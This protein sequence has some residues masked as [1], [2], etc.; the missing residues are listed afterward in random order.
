MQRSEELE[1]DPESGEVRRDDAQGGWPSGAEGAA[2]LSH[3]E[4]GPEGARSR[5]VDVG[6]KEATARS[7][8]A[9]ALVVFPEGELASI[10]AGG[11]P[12]GP[13]EEVA[14]VAGILAAKDTGRL[15]PMCHP[16]GLDLVEVH[17]EDLGDDR[18]EVLC[19]ASCTG[20][21]G[22]EMEAMVG[23]SVAAL[24][25]YDMTKALSKGIRIEGVELL[26]KTGGK[27]GAWR[28]A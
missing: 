21:T 8:L 17:L 6:A 19:R 10:L 3:I 14:R 2:G 27:S 23:A 26:E 24:T 7:A 11:G 16:L 9:R 1:P 20:R 4:T 5:M 12:K 15:I 28:R 22:V 18:L 25:V 13:I